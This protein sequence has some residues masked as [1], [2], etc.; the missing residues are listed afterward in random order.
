[1]G[2]CCNTQT[3]QGTAPK[4]VCPANGKTYKRVSRETI[5][6]HLNKPW[7]VDLPE[8][9]YYFC[10][11]KDCDV[12]Y[13]GED[14]RMFTQLDLRTTVGQKSENL[15]RPVCYCFDVTQIDLETRDTAK[16]FIIQQTMN[17]TCHCQIR[18]PSGRCCLKDIPK[19]TP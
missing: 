17:G 9:E 12:V 5:L 8:Q 1:M 16:D 19:E 14:Q 2:A 3:S 4:A 11:S 7:Q 10:D 15:L 6:H 18:N 13:Y